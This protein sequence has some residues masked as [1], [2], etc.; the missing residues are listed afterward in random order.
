MIRAALPSLLLCAFVT[1]APVAH[2]GS[3]MFSDAPEPPKAPAGR[4]SIEIDHPTY[5]M[6]LTLE[7]KLETNDAE[8][9]RGR[10]GFYVLVASASALGRGALEVSAIEAA[11]ECTRGRP[12]FGL[13]RPTIDGFRSSTYAAYFG[14]Y[15]TRE[16][17]AE[18]RDSIQPCVPDTYIARGVIQ[19]F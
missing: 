7:Q 9:S 19:R 8:F 16:Q 11:G 13:T 2:A 17:A 10:S 5:R 1:T 15:M 12:K 14:P 18:V 6:R 4:T 3:F